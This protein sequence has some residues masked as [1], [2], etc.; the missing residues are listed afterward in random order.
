[1]SAA[2]LQE[3]RIN[4]LYHAITRFAVT[5]LGFG[6]LL[7]LTRL[8]EW[9]WLGS[10][11]NFNDINIKA[12][13]LGI[14]TDIVWIFFLSG[15]ALI[16]YFLL[17]LL[18]SRLASILYQ[19]ILT[20]SLIFHVGLV[21]YFSLS[22]LPLGADVYAY[23][24]K[25]LWDTVAA[26]GQL[27]LWVII[28]AIITFGLIY[29]LLS[30]SRRLNL[31]LRYSTYGSCIAL[32]VAVGVEVLSPS[33]SVAK[34]ELA[35]YSMKNKSL[36]FYEKSLD[37]FNIP[38]EIYYDFYLENEV[39]KGYFVR[40]NFINNNFPFLHSA[41]YPD[42][43]SPYLDTLDSPPNIVFVMIEG[44]GKAYSG[45]D[46]YL[47]SFT[48]FMD[49]LIQHSLYWKN[50]LSTTGRTFGMLP[51]VM[52][53]LPFGQNGFM[54]TGDNMPHHHSILS[55][56]RSNGYQTSYVGGFD[57]TFDN[58]LQFLE[59]QK[60]DRIEG[61]TQF[62]GKYK[63]LPAKGNGFSWGY[64]DFE[65]YDLGLKSM[66]ND[67]QP[68][69]HIFQTQTSHDPF[70]IPDV[71]KYEQLYKAQLAKNG[72]TVET[73]AFYERYKSQLMTIIYADEALKSFIKAYSKRAD[74]EKTIFII[75]GDHRLPEIPLSTVI[76]RYHVPLM[77]Y[78]PQ[79]SQPKIFEPVVT[80]FELVPTLLA[81]LEN[82]YALSIPKE[83]AW[84]GEVLDTA[85]T[86]RNKLSHPLMR[87][88]NEL[89]D[90][91]HDSLF[92]AN[93]RLFKL[94]PNLYI[95]ETNDP[96]ALNRLKQLLDD[97][98]SKN[99]FATNNNRILR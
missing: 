83:V 31:S 19:I 84:M 41:K 38:S 88:K 12:L 82:Q 5:S 66:L 21:Y 60:I 67:D 16:P 10:Q 90:Y 70:L 53:S 44:L 80:H 36:Y 64:G 35:Y 55:I 23:T 33:T 47:G 96:K 78:S 63:P 73:P 85:S 98:K 45:P 25:D 46:A 48:P 59:R 81:Y 27:N 89:V 52:A 30:Q 8:I 14:Y 50:C 87:N 26:S 71:A 95:E 42:V 51:S 58:A 99:N 91:L 20:L 4:K 57:L 6:I 97:F 11:N 92:Y 22:Y 29:L 24:F 17:S 18:S 65:V 3:P 2:D 68:G 39:G 77:I 54:E 72:K 1:M 61:I 49:S 79:V 43:L 37:H 56:L 15:I 32:V 13:I 74:F 93:G 34:S 69:V 76:D 62:D 40:K 86:Y 75:S 9:I 7:L 28:G 94:Y